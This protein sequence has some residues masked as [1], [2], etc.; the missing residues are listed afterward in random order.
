M[1]TLVSDLWL[2]R[3]RYK[4][5]YTLLT[6]LVVISLGLTA[7]MN[8][9]ELRPA[10]QQSAIASGA[11]SLSSI[12]PD[13]VIDW[14]YHILQRASFVIFGVTSFSIKLPSLILGVLTAL[15]VFLLIRS[16][17]RRNTAVI[18]GLIAATTPALLFMS[19]DGTPIITYSTLVIWLFVVGTYVTRNHLFRTFW[20]TIGAVLL[21]ISLYIPL[22]VYIT[23]TLIVTVLI[24]PHIRHVIKKVTK[25]RLI[26]AIILGVLAMVPLAYAI[27][28]KPAI[29]LTLLGLPTGDFSLATNAMT[30]ISDLFG[31]F[32]ASTE[33]IFRPIF[34]L[35]IILL[36]LL[37]L[38][39]LLTEKYTARSY[40]ILIL[41]LLTFLVALA[42]PN[43]AL[44]LFPVII[45]TLATGVATLIRNWYRLFPLNPYA[46]VG[47]LVPLA[48]LVGGLVFL[49]VSRYASTFR[50]D[51]VVLTN[52]SSDLSLLRST[53]NNNPAASPT[54]LVTSSEENA[55][56]SLVAH[57]DHRFYVA[58]TVDKSSQILVTNAAHNSKSTKP[59]NLARIITSDRSVNANRFYLY[60]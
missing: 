50:Y 51:P 39:K 22:G 23:L 1:K 55:F 32:S 20:K 46:R 47:G 56:Y 37:G 36:S 26:L 34:S 45:V 52:Y 12:S 24:H 33:S 7:L 30:T 38:Y 13:M 48:I 54:R 27:S 18:T 58:A 3:L 49:G 16:W 4:I 8:P 19:Q 21:A 35:P 29:A 6:V 11:L 10:E 57:Y 17:F 15:G 44:N 28:M 31:F 60:K 40:A 53:L 5:G 43:Y 42:N 9:G 59:S 25:L 14:P 2:Y 41:A